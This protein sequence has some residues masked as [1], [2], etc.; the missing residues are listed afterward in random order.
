MVK[1]SLAAGFSVAFAAVALVASDGV[2]AQPTNTADSPAAQ[3]L[4]CMVR[5]SSIESSAAC[6]GPNRR[7]TQSRLHSFLLLQNGR[8]GQWKHRKRLALSRNAAFTSVFAQSNAVGN[9]GRGM[10]DCEDS[11]IESSLR[12]GLRLKWTWRRCAASI[13]GR[14]NGPV[15]RCWIRN[16]PSRLARL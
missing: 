3:I 1:A 14:Q 5:V 13:R 2:P 10:A 15:K 9:N 12:A 11:T 7:S 6:F 4:R 8:L 16:G